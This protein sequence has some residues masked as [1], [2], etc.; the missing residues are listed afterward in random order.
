MFVTSSV[1]LKLDEERE[2]SCSP[3]RVVRNS[4]S[5]EGFDVELKSLTGE[6]R[7]LFWGEGVEN[8]GGFPA[9]GLVQVVAWQC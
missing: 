3:P 2:R 9:L 1:F 5:A 8:P 4:P 7:R 6:K